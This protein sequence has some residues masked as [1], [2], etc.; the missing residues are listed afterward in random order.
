MRYF[1]LRAGWLVW[2]EGARVE[3]FHCDKGARAERKQ[4]DLKKQQ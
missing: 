4:I 1:C 2:E 3:S